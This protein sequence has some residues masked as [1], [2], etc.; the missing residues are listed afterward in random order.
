MRYIFRYLYIV[1]ITLVYGGNFYP[2]LPLN[3]DS[4]NRNTIDHLIGIMVEFPEEITDNPNTSGNGKILLNSLDLMPEVLEKVGLNTKDSRGL[5]KQVKFRWS[6]KAGCSCPCSPGFR[7][8]V[9]KNIMAGP[10]SSNI[11]KEY[12][13]EKFNNGRFDIF[14][15]LME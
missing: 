9:T 14:V 10:D 4:N 15:D 2:T 7:I 1:L 11:I 12:W 5:I 8:S 3:I 6:Q 13:H